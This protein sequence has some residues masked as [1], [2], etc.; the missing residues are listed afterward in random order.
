MTIVLKGYGVENVPMENDPVRVTPKFPA[1][2]TC[3][4][5]QHPFF[6]LVHDVPSDRCRH[7]TVVGT[8]HH[9]SR[10]SA[11][12]DN[13]LWVRQYFVEKASGTTEGDGIPHLPDDGSKTIH[14]P[15]VIGDK[16]QLQVDLDGEPVLPQPEGVFVGFLLDVQQIRLVVFLIWNEVPVLDTRYISSP[17]DRPEREFHLEYLLLT[18]VV[19]IQVTH[20]G[21]HLC[22]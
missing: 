17:Q 2:E 8:R 13:L 7:L 12:A 9:I 6:H 11:A 4:T 15:K 21:C 3:Q 20:H 19:L 1:L 5:W 16:L 10:R 22:R 14:F 18:G